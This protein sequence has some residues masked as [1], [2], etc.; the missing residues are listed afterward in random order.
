V[1]TSSPASNWEREGIVW[2]R[3]S[4]REVKSLKEEEKEKEKKGRGQAKVQAAAK[5][6]HCC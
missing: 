6:P 3:Q 2:L 1:L 5:C 4:F